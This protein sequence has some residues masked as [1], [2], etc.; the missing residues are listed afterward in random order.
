[1]AQLYMA[2]FPEDSMAEVK[3]ALQGCWSSN[4]LEAEVELDVEKG[5]AHFSKQREAAR[6]AKET[7]TNGG[8]GE[9]GAGPEMEDVGASVEAIYAFLRSGEIPSGKTKK[10]LSRASKKYSLQDRALYYKQKRKGVLE[11]KE[12]EEYLRAAHSDA[13]AG[14]FGV[15]KTY[16]SL[17]QLGELYWPGMFQD[18]A[19]VALDRDACRTHLPS[20]MTGR[21][22]LSPFPVRRHAV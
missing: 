9:G 13:L 11:K 18:A 1:M 22:H 4:K 8:L 2:A 12:R 16:K 7:A 19:K 14:H 15:H 6:G 3:R 21:R 10:Q 17:K 20:E 5:F